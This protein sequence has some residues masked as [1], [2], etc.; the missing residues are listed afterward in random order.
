MDGRLYEDANV[1]MSPSDTPSQNGDKVLDESN[2]ETSSSEQDRKAPTKRRDPEK[3]SGLDGLGPEPSVE[4]LAHGDSD[5]E[6]IVYP[7]GL[8]LF[9]LASV[10]PLNHRKHSPTPDEISAKHLPIDL[11]SASQSSSS[12]STAPSSR[13]PSPASRTNSTASTM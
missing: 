3:I 2:Q 10:L 1:A 13:P 8:K 11:H 9:I 4:R 6:E 5:E 7:S 12:L